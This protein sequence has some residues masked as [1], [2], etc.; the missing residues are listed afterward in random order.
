MTAATAQITAAL[1]ESAL[2]MGQEPC[3]S[4]TGSVETS[5]VEFRSAVLSCTGLAAI[6][7]AGLA[8]GNGFPLEIMSGYFLLAFAIIACNKSPQN[9]GVWQLIK[10][11][12]QSKAA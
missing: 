6:E 10:F 3:W 11:A 4:C 1:S 9:Y 12:R 7:S 2:G 8:S 5:V